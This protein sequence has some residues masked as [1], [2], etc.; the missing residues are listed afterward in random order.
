VKTFV[1][2]LFVPAERGQHP[3]DSSLSGLVEEVASGCSERFASGGELL[4]FLAAPERKR[5][6]EPIESGVSS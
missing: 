2:R 4:A 3:S 6:T 5:P 1:V